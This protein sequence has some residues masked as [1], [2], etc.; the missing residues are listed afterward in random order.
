MSAKVLQGISE[1][2]SLE[3]VINDHISKGSVACVDAICAYLRS[4]VERSAARAGSHG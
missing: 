3:A 2:I 4:H 1:G